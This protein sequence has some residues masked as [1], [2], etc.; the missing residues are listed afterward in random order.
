[1]VQVRRKTK[2]IKP[3]ES[4]AK[5]KK[6]KLRP[7]LKY[8][9]AAA[10]AGGAAYF[11]FGGSSYVPLPA[12]P[13]QWG[14]TSRNQAS[15]SSS[16]NLAFSPLHL[17]AENDINVVYGG[18][19]PLPDGVY[20]W[21]RNG[22]IIPGEQSSKLVAGQFKF[23]RG[24]TLKVRLIKNGG[25]ESESTAPA[26]VENASPKIATVKLEQDKPTRRDTLTVKVDAAD[27]D[28]DPV[29][30]A[31]RWMKEDG[32]VVGTDAAVSGALYS[33]KD[34]IIVEVTPSDGLSQGRPVK[35][36]G[37]LYNA[38][39][40]ITS[41]PPA[42]SGKEYTYQVTA[43]DPDKE[44]VTF[45]LSKGPAG[46]TIHPKSG[47]INW[48]FTEKDAGSHPVEI[49]VSDSDGEGDVQ[50]FDLPLTFTAVPTTPSSGGGT[51]RAEK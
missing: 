34:K 9:G 7:F 23:K 18:S 16:N 4:A 49:R 1:M 25:K 15:A 42:I 20:E 32:S 31:Y 3:E 17:T 19:G 46:M 28:G 39:P 27:A 24:D 41:A 47:V 14:G 13:P 30:F 50:S 37:I 22:L 11:Y 29:T 43:D 40:K 8:L 6:R 35:A 38:L 33:K 12:M 26:V 51:A 36:E 2:K 5:K 44:P 45:T 48:P 10:L 21:E